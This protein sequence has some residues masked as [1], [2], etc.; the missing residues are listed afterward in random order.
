MSIC[1][2]MLSHS[3][4]FFMRK[5]LFTFDFTVGVARLAWASPLWR[6]SAISHKH[7]SSYIAFYSPKKN[8]RRG[9]TE[10]TYTALLRQ[11]NWAAKKE[12]LFLWPI[13]LHSS[14]VQVSKASS[15]IL[16]RKHEQKHL[17]SIPLNN[18]SQEYSSSL[19]L[20]FLSSKILKVSFIW[21]ESNANLKTI[22]N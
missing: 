2:C 7:T 8:K 17:L 4:R 16:R 3:I 15:D 14:V 1:T 12:R 11:E 21:N 6:S 10:N 5:G 20:G 9:R 13:G 18:W 19:M 22:V